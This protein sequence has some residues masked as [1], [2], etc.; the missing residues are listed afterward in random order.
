VALE[1]PDIPG[2]EDVV[3]WFGYWPVFHDAEVLSIT[4]NRSTGAM[5]EIHTFERTA[6]LD[7]RGF[8]VLAKHAIVTFILE[9][10]SLNQ[11]GIATTRIDYFNH[12]NVLSSAGV[13]KTAEG[14]K[15]VLEGCFGVDGVIGGENLSVKLRP[16][17]PSDGIYAD[18]SRPSPEIHK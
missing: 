12:Q 14:Y 2:A 7:T 5:V 10:F 1:I 8:Y 3:R 17:I 11:D 9:G 15:L 4:L 16:G 18:A 6:E 13:E